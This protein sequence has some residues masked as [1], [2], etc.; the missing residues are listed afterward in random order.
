MLLKKGSDFRKWGAGL[1][2]AGILLWVIAI[3]LILGDI[4]DW[5]GFEFD[6][7][8]ERFVIVFLSTTSFN[9]GALLYFVG[10]HFLGLGQI[11]KNTDKEYEEEVIIEEGV[12]QVVEVE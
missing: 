6:F 4:S 3:L 1:F 9:M 2:V 11:A 12:E 7:I 8:L 10:L 5:G